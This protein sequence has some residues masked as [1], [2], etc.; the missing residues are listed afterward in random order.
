LSEHGLK[1]VGDDLL[2][3]LELAALDSLV[4]GS[5]QEPR[6]PDV[7]FPISPF[8]A[9]LSEALNPLD[10]F[11]VR[12]GTPSIALVTYREMPDSEVAVESERKNPFTIVGFSVGKLLWLESFS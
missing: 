5:S 12:H 1:S 6:Y 11:H 3:C 7:Q 8:S 2:A 10:T 9:R 4:D